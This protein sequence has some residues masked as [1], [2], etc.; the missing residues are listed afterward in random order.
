MAAKTVSRIINVIADVVRVEEPL[1]TNIDV[2]LGF[3][4]RL[5]NRVD[6]KWHRMPTESR[7]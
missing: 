4:V 5:T 3:G 1:V 2:S 6:S 7:G